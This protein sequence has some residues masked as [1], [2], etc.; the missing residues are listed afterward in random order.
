MMMV[1]TRPS[2]LVT[3][4]ARRIGAAIARAF[5]EAGWHV[6]VHYRRS[7][8]EAEALAATLPSAEIAAADLSQPG[9]PTRLVERV[10]VSPRR[11]PCAG[12]GRGQ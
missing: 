1:M 2:V 6:I 11:R 4:G 12:P 7:Q 10:R 8:G 3:G 5:G 9:A